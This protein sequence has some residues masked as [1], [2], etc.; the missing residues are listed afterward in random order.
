M[1]MIL[2]GKNKQESIGE[3]IWTIVLFLLQ[4]GIN[5]IVM[6]FWEQKKD[7]VLLH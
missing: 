4:I 1:S 3:M 5:L 2:I 6:N 7:Y